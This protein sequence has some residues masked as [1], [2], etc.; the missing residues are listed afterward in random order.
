MPP[1]PIV[2]RPAALASSNHIRPVLGRADESVNL[3]RM[4]VLAL[5]LL[6]VRQHL[7]TLWAFASWQFIRH[8][9]SFTAG[10]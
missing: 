2:I 6:A 10:D 1:I 9:C 7:D 5:S 3:W 4:P 8:D